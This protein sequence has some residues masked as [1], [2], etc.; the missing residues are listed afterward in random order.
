MKPDLLDVGALRIEPAAEWFGQRLVG[1]LPC[2]ADALRQ[3]VAWCLHQ[4]MNGHA[5]LDCAKP[6][7][8]R[9]A[10]ADDGDE[11]EALPSSAW[12]DALTAAACVARAQVGS[13]ASLDAALVLEGSQLFLARCRMQEIRIAV[14]LAR[15]AQQPACWSQGADRAAVLEAAI[16]RS[17]I[18][19]EPEQAAAVRVAATRRLSIITGGPGT[20]K[21]TVAARVIAAVHAVAPGSVLLLA[22]T[23]KAA[24]R[25]QQS[26]RQA[27]ER[28]ELEAGARTALAALEARTLHSAILRESGAALRGARLV[29]LDETSMVDLE[30]MDGLL[31]LLHQDASL[32]MLGDPFQLASV[33]A[34]SVLGD[35]VPQAGDGAH[36]LLASTVTLV[37]SR[38]FPVESGV[39]RLA[40]LV[41]AGDADAA[42][43]LLRSGDA[44]LRWEP[45]SKPADVVA[46][47][48]AAR[49]AFGDVCRILCGHRHGPDGSLRVN[50][51]IE[52]GRGGHGGEPRYDGRPVIIRVNDANTGLRNGD[53]GLMRFDAGQWWVEFTELCMKLPADRLPSHESA[54][55]LTIHKTQGSEY[56]SVV[57]T[58]PARPSPVLTRE[59]LYT[60]ITR[61]KG[62]VTVVASEAALRAAIGRPILRHGGLRGRLRSAGRS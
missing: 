11:A 12:L 44:S 20:G 38:R 28:A 4:W 35:I 48:I 29:I 37:R 7:V 23:G 53:A 56:E 16:S 8:G 17:C 21:T 61:T 42:I 22:P 40:A 27:C 59:L 32:V 41:K 9:L 33:E 54:F 51:A 26:V 45:A 34:G 5:C 60:G 46:K 25:L 24:Q 55:A 50:A 39:G 57:V 47:A 43:A 52:R 15:C 62:A 58:L 14:A 19:L 1:V 30:R 3:P 10:D 36:P 2:A 18:G 13:L 31:E 6:I 49:R